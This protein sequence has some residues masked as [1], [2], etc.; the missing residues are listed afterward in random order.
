MKCACDSFSWCLR[1]FLKTIMFIRGYYVLVYF[2]IPF[3]YKYMPLIILSRTKS[4]I[5]GNSL[6]KS[7]GMVCIHFTLPGP[8]SKR[9]IIC[10]FDLV[11]FIFSNSIAININ[12]TIK[13]YFCF[14]LCICI[15]INIQGGVLGRTPLYRVP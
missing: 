1:E 8:Y 3:V 6:L 4:V 15:H 7:R 13:Q 10:I 5:H 14:L 9:D 2:D 12:Q 11:W